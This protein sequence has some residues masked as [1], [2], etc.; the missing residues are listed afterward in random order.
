[1]AVPLEGPPDELSGLRMFLEEQ[2]AAVLRK[3]DG[4]SDEQA[5]G[6]PTHPRG[7]DGAVGA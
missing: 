5:T 3:L 1:M 7:H 2:R 4:L 6:R